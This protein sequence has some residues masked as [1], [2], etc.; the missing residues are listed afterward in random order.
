MRLLLRI[1]YVWPVVV[2]QSC[3][4]LCTTA[5]LKSRKALIECKNCHRRAL[6]VRGKLEASRK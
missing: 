1:F 5:W 4:L 6:N 2:V 3:A